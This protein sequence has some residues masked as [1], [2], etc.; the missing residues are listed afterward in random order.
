MAKV[1]ENSLDISAYSI[2]SRMLNSINLFILPIS[3]LMGRSAIDG[4]ALPLCAAFLASLSRVP[5]NRF[6][7]LCIMITGMATNDMV[8]IALKLI[9][10]FVIITLY[11]RFFAQ[12]FGEKLQYFILSASVLMPGIISASLNGGYSY[13]YLSVLFHA[14][15]AFAL[16]FV[17]RGTALLL[18]VAANGSS[19]IKGITAE[20][21]ISL[22][23]VIF[24]SA[25]GIMNLT[26]S[27][28]SIGVIISI[29]ALIILSY[30]YGPGVGASSGIIAGLAVILTN[31]ANPIIA[32]L[33]AFCGMFC[34]F[35]GR[36]GKIG[37]VLGFLLGNAILT[38]YLSVPGITLL[39]FRDILLA[40]LLF[41]LLPR[42]FFKLL[43]KNLGTEGVS[44]INANQVGLMPKLNK[45]VSDRLK[46]FALVFSNL[47]ESCDIMGQEIALHTA[48]SDNAKL[49]ER[50]ATIACR[51]CSMR[52][53]CWE[54]NFINTYSI[55]LSA[56]EL[57]NTKGRIDID[58]LPQEFVKR[59]S[60]IEA[61]TDEI[62]RSLEIQRLESFWRTR[63]GTCRSLL[64]KQLSGVASAISTFSNE[65]GLDILKETNSEIS[66][67]IKSSLENLGIRI[68]DLIILINVN[69]RHEVSIVHTG[70]QGRRKCIQSFER[71]VSS[72]LERNMVK[73]SGE[74]MCNH[75]TGVC[76][77][78]LVEDNVFKV[79]TGISQSSKAPGGICGDSCMFLTKDEG[80]YVAAV[81]DGMGFGCKAS[82][83]STSTVNLLQ[84]YIESGFD[85]DVAV[86]LINSIL[87]SCTDSETYATMDVVS[88]D[89]L[90]GKA[91][92]IKAG[93]APGFIKNNDAV[94]CI[95]AVSLP[96]GILD[97]V[98]PEIME[99]RLS[100]GSMV[101]LMTD[102]AYEALECGEA[103]AAGYISQLDTTNPQ[104]LADMLLSKAL[105]EESKR[106]NKDDMLIMAAK[107]W[108]KRL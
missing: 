7:V 78:R 5:V 18:Q 11:G 88:I 73:A 69:G 14:F 53:H 90:T 51:D 15:L 63:L 38:F 105:S 41:L 44:G 99:R 19:N 27:G 54:R 24:L 82:L 22:S 89:M 34:G 33:L 46:G 29:S 9:V 58:A 67:L 98:E 52:V 4:M 100:D 81:S 61:V 85:C 66:G 39:Y 74:C 45:I 84:N 96:A 106:K 48:D 77:L 62:N 97:E 47:S 70:C 101:V 23:T 42:K 65:V 91:G 75:D 35:F 1:L 86:G 20:Q 72:A 92:F 79:S 43:P 102:G 30:I 95:R 6:I 12:K 25:T 49:V 16:T 59:C 76:N 64:S 17:F 26:V 107:V 60:H 103:G 36:F 31:F 32:V 37:A 56:L 28:I 108:K 104:E 87:V 83:K 57:L 50:A 94:E 3:L 8:G 71:I 13:D 10:A 40:S 21:A 55:V 80:L 93:A 2:S 68:L